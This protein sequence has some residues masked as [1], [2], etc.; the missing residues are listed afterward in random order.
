MKSKR[1]FLS[2]VFIIS[3]FVALF[4]FLGKANYVNTKTK[5]KIIVIPINKTVRSENNQIIPAPN[6][7]IAYEEEKIKT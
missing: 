7:N 1:I 2:F 3:L 4:M 5:E 6:K